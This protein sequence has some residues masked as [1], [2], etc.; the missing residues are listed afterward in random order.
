MRYQEEDF[1]IGHFQVIQNSHFQNEAKCKTFLLK[2]SFIK[3]LWVIGSWFY[4]YEN[5]ES[6][7]H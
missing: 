2:M 5:K 3:S 7:S 6:F 4:L 1:L